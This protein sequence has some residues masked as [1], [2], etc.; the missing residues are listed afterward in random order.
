MSLTG[1]SVTGVARWT[2]LLISPPGLLANLVSKAKNF[3]DPTKAPYTVTVHVAHPGA[4]RKSS[5][6]YK[7]YLSEEDFETLTA[8]P[9]RSR[10]QHIVLTTNNSVLCTYGSRMAKGHHFSWVCVDEHHKVKN[11][12]S[13]FSQDL[14]SITM[15]RRTSFVFASGKPTDKDVND[16]ALPCICY[17]GTRQAQSW[18]TTG[19]RIKS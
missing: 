1:P 10:S 3:L 12:K 15:Q 2:C 18:T 9:V 17:R 14:S 11:K 19:L 6:M 7:Q 13:V 16:L 5:W 8:K 4:K